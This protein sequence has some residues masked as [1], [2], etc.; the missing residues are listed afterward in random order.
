MARVASATALRSAPRRSMHSARFER[1]V[2]LSGVS[3]SASE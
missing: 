1:S 3:P 2:E